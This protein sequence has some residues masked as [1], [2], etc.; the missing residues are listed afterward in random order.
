MKLEFRFDSK[1]KRLWADKATIIVITFIIIII[2]IV[3]G[4]AAYRLRQ[5]KG[6]LRS[7][8]DENQPLT[9]GIPPVKPETL[10]ADGKTASEAM[11]ADIK[12]QHGNKFNIIFFY[13]GYDDQ[14]DALLYIKVMQEALDLVEPFK[15]LSGHIAF[16]IFTTEGQKCH[17]EAGAKKILKCDQEMVESFNRLGIERFKLVVL[18]PLDFVPNAKVARGKNSA[19]YMPTF[20]GALTQQEL[21]RWLGQFFMHELG[22]SLGLRDE[23]SR[24]RPAESIIDK[25]SADQLSSNIAY[26]PAK[27][28][29][30]PDKETAK[31]WWGDYVGV[32][33]GVDFYSGCA[34][35]DTYYFPQ[36]NTLM[37]ANPTTET[38]GQVSEDYLRGAISCFYSGK[39]SLIWPAGLEATYSAKLKN[40][41]T[42]RAE[43]PNFWEE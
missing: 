37:S 11:I 3:G 41:D 12:K 36:E 26:R 43:Y 13:D 29:C 38:F 25:E 5:T 42:F 31:T 10:P 21:N 20:Q 28:N 18:S 40:C 27:P 14:K 30:A 9:L 33:A 2:V 17:V 15:S 8:V 1:N 7:P 16:K 35:R 22:H 39:E 6:D 32:F 34:G 23:Y 24:Q 19:I 4:F